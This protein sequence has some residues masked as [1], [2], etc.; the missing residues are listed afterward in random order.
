MMRYAIGVDLGGTFIKYALIDNTG[1]FHFEGKVPSKADTTSE[2]VI[3]QIV[4]AVK[5]CVSYAEDNNLKIEGVGIGTPGIVDES[6]R[7]ILGGAENIK[8][9]VNIPLA[10]LVEYKT[11]LPTKVNNDANLM[12]L[13]EATFGAAKG[14]SDVIFITVGTG[15]G[16]AIV[17]DKKLYGGFKNRGSELGHIPF[18]HGGEPCSCGSLGCLEAYASTT[19]LVKRFSRKAENI[20]IEKN[21]IDGKLIIDLYKQGHPLATECML[22]H[23]D[24]LGHGIAGFINI[25]SPEKVVIGGGISEAGDFYIEELH[26]SAIKYAMKDSSV[27]T[28]VV[29]ATLGNRAGAMGAACMVFSNIL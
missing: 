21:E 20:L 27:N 28:R 25:F 17:I 4:F 15:I 8:G 18:I 22:E 24:F 26:K 9:W 3:R 10:S 12:G 29:G 14:C 16:G 2:T 11:S 7:T 6:Q 19:A 1:N 13:G 5:E 23:W